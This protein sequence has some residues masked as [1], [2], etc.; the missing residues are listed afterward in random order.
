MNLRAKFGEEISGRER[1]WHLE[2]WEAKQ[3]PEAKWDINLELQQRSSGQT[4]IWELIVKYKSKGPGV[5]LA[6]ED[7]EGRVQTDS[8]SSGAAG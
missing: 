5:W 6:V 2:M 4:L 8:G 3:V 1:E 7:K